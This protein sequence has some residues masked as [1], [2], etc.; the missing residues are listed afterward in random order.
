MYKTCLD[1]SNGDIKDPALTNL[2]MTEINPTHQLP[3]MLILV[4][5]FFSYRASVFPGGHCFDQLC[6]MPAVLMTP[7]YAMVCSKKKT[8]GLWDIRE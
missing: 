8:V 6:W 7:S 4:L 1:I 2:S 3:R 5:N